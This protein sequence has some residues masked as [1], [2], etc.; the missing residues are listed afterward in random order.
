[1]VYNPD[2]DE[3]M[4]DINEVM[5]LLRWNGDSESLQF[6]KALLEVNRALAMED[7]EKAMRYLTELIQAF[8][9][10]GRSEFPDAYTHITGAYEHMNTICRNL[11]EI[12]S[13]ITTGEKYSAAP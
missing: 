3:A 11:E 12:Q 5:H 6:W 13:I 8:E 10:S 1:M 9:L 2:I 7:T 4:D